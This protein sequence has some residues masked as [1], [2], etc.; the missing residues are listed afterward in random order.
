MNPLDALSLAPVSIVGQFGN[1][2]EKA[3]G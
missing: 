2:T 1:C 3:E